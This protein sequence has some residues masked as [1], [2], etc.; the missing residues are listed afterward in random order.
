MTD[1][2]FDS[3]QKNPFKYVTASIPSQIK[4]KEKKIYRQGDILF[5]KIENFP[6]DIASKP[7]NVIAEGE[8]SGHYHL[9]NSGALY[10]V[11]NSEDLYLKA[12]E[13][14]KITHNEHLPIKLSPGNYKIIRQREYLG[15]GAGR[16]HVEIIRQVID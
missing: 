15:K 11:L 10:E 14:T 5:K 4:P 13:K 16:E 2:K 7:D 12:G 9:L 6:L 3:S 1:T 8:V